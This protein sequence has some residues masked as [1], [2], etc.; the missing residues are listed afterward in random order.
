MWGKWNPRAL[1]VG[2]ADWCGH[3]GNSIDLPQKIKNGEHTLR[4][5]GPRKKRKKSLIEMKTHFKQIEHCVLN[6]A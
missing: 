5:T 3:C 6:S 1:L 4:T 2:N